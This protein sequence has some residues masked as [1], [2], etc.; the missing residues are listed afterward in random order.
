[1]SFHPQSLTIFK[2]DKIVWTNNDPVVHTLW[3]VYAEDKSTYLMSNP[4]LPGESW[5]YVFSD[6]AELRYYCFD[7][8]WVN[9][10]ITVKIQTD[11]WLYRDDTRIRNM[12]VYYP[13]GDLYWERGPGLGFVRN[14]NDFISYIGSQGP[15]MTLIPVYYPTLVTQLLVFHD[16]DFICHSL[17]D[18]GRYVDWLYD[19][20]H[21]SNIGFWGW[22]F[23]GISDADFDKWTINILTNLNVAGVIADASLVQNKFVYE[24]MPWFPISSGRGFCTTARDSR[25][26]LMNLI[27][28]PNYG[29][30]ND[31]SWMCLHWNGAVS[32]GTIKVALGDA[33]HT[34][35]PYTEFTPYGRQILDRA[36]TGLLSLNPNTLQNMPY[37]ANE[38]SLSPGIT[39]PELG[40]TAGSY[41]T[42]Y[43]RQDV[44]WH[45]GK[46]VTAYDCV[47]NMR[48]LRQYKPGRYSSTWAMLVYE[49]AD[50]PYKFNAYFYTPSL[51]WA[52]NAAETALLSPKHITD[53]AETMYGSILTGWE[54]AFNSYEDLM[55]YAPPAKYSFMKQVVG[56]GPFVYDYANPST[57]TARVQRFEEYFINAPAIGS[58]VGEWRV[59]P[60]TTYTYKVLVQNI[61][62]KDSVSGELV[63]MTVDIMVYEDDV[64]TH[65]I[66]DVLL[67][68]WDFT[69]L[70]PYTTGA[71]SG[72]YH[73]VTVKIYEDTLGLVHTYDHEYYAVPREDVTTCA[74]NLRD[75]FVDVKDILR[76]AIAYGSY[77]G[78]L[79]WDPPCDVNDDFFVDVKDLLAI[80]LKYGWL[81]TPKP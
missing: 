41:A 1:F 65:S 55:G 11:Y 67:D 59:N 72:G 21:S 79:R 44:Y 42:F 70:G 25:G 73:H 15:V 80:A 75:C 61:A 9:G 68:A 54:P 48:L 27:S 22:N 43:L 77:P 34:M 81:G 8:L 28:M 36:V 19:M 7:S 71:L 78:S 23:C 56:C 32:G 14:F 18:L 40:I 63:G 5:S 3:F 17:T 50:G 31:W 60:Y 20:L 47:N 51:Y 6:S 4:I 29:P 52:D 69:Y 24:L 2:D 53:A 26:E 13:A 76:A 62:A 46:P 66:N 45:D 38:Y 57:M 49:E 74:G 16:F 10:S 30:M 33:W 64:L 12:K 37:I 35:N 39:I 58:V